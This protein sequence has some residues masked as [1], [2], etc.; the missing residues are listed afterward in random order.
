M[1]FLNLYVLISTLSLIVVESQR[2]VIDTRITKNSTQ[3]LSRKRRF[4]LPRVNGW[5]LEAEFDVIV[6]LEDPLDK[7]AFTF[8]L[9][10]D[11]DSTDLS[12][13]R[14][15]SI[16]RSFKPQTD[17]RSQTLKTIEKYLNR[18]GGVVGNGRACVLRAI[19]EVAE[20]PLTSDGFLG[21]LVS[22]M[23]V[24]SYAL[25]GVN[26]T[27][28]NETDYTQA[29]KD[30]YFGDGCTH[31]HQD[32]PVSLFEYVGGKEDD[33]GHFISQYIGPSYDKIV[34]DCPYCDIDNHLDSMYGTYGI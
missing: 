20:A 30:G 22:T 4:F 7:I 8:K 18:M 5:K 17:H 19:C 33:S 1:G 28:F 25:D 34:S 23:L 2:D 3:I 31:Y 11:I 6:P 12:G 9:A 26:G 21:D 16:D 14:R 27:I 10:Y 24:P 13:K 29:Q 15:S 32:C